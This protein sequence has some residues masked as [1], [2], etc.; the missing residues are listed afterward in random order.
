M[1]DY[2]Q[3]RVELTTDPVAMGYAGLSDADAA[4]RIMDPTRR[5]RPQTSVSSR[6]VLNQIDNGAWPATGTNQDKLAAILG[7]GQID[8]SNVN[9]RSI[10]GALF[11][12]SGATAATRT[13]L[14]ALAS[15]SISR[16][17]ELGLGP[18]AALDVSRARSGVW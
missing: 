1:P 6:E 3:L 10:I 9:T 16:A 4:T 18:V 11:P 5:S 17:E 14:E 7:A 2:A 8:P 13:R 15:V 12:A